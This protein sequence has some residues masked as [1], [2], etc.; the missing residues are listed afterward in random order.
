MWRYF[1]ARF[2]VLYGAVFTPI[3]HGNH[4]DLAPI[5]CCLQCWLALLIVLTDE[6]AVGSEDHFHIF[7]P[8][9]LGDIPSIHSSSQ[10]CRR[11][12]VP[13]LVRVAVLNTRGLLKTG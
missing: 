6:L 13:D 1:F 12:G 9:L 4:T 5:T 7:V 10:Q 8:Q 3:S 11:A 2:L